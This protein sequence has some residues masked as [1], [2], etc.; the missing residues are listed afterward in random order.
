MNKTTFLRPLSQEGRPEPISSP[1]RIDPDKN[2]LL[3]Q[4]LKLGAVKDGPNEKTLYRLHTGVLAVFIKSSNPLVFD[5][6]EKI[7]TSDA[8]SI[9]GYMDSKQLR[10]VG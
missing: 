9:F 2:F 3:S 6:I 1:G 5:K 10:K 4:G 7:S 8:F